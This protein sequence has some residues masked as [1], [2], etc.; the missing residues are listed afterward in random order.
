MTA[1]HNVLACNAPLAGAARNRCVP[2]SVGR[3]TTA[4]ARKLAVLL[5]NMALFLASPFI[6]LAYAVLLPF[7]GF[8]MLL[9]IAT[10]GLRKSRA[11]AAASVGPQPARVEAPAAMPECVAV[12]AEEPHEHGVRAAAM[13]ALKLLAAPFAG[14]AFVVLM[15][16]AALGALAWTGLNATSM[17]TA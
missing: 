2:V 9:W 14:L 12:A 10:E 16:I 8:G 13:L 5:K 11:A 4:L 7:V 15:P 17:R 6:G 1:L 3:R